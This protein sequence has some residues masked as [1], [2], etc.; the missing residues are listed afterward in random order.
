[1]LQSQDR[2]YTSHSTI[3]VEISGGDGAHNLNAAMVP[4]YRIP[5]FLA[6]SQENKA[7]TTLE[8]LF[9]G[10]AN[11]SGIFIA[12]PNKGATGVVCDS[13]F[14]P[15]INYDDPEYNDDSNSSLISRF[16]YGVNYTVGKSGV[17][18]RTRTVNGV[19]T[20]YLDYSAQVIK[21]IGFAG[22]MYM[23]GFGYDVNNYFVPSNKTVSIQEYSN[24]GG[25]LGITR[26]NHYL[27]SGDVIIMQCSGVPT[28]NGAIG[29]IGVVDRNTFIVN[30]N[31]VTG[32]DALEPPQTGRYSVENIDPYAADGEGGVN[33]WENTV[34][35]TDDVNAWKA[36]PIDLR[37]DASR[38]VWCGSDFFRNDIIYGYLDSDIT[39]ANGRNDP[40]P[41]RIKTYKLAT[42]PT[43]IIDFALDTT[44]TNSGTAM[45]IV[46]NNLELIGGDIIN[47][48]GTNTSYDGEQTVIA[49]GTIETPNDVVYF[50]KRYD[51]GANANVTDIGYIS[52]DDGTLFDIPRVVDKKYI[53]YNYDTHLS[54]ELNSKCAD[55][56]SGCITTQDDIFVVAIKKGPND[57]RPI[58][59][60]FED[61]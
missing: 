16:G 50:N 51:S 48:I 61:K 9:I 40:T 2:Q 17:V 35:F 36:G 44:Y 4:D 41:F 24:Q 56:N 14:F 32:T 45:R 23:A 10:I 52:F 33:G 42:L 39:P 19:T 43:Y 55:L 58:Y 22:P 6:S 59:I 18:T 27:L 12:N 11:K 31:F 15:F 47:I 21:S 57:I 37:W 54:V 34:E 25:K 46:P 20:S 53:V 3:A 38:Q 60:G 5:Y 1:M 30:K 29:V 26:N 13:G 7:A 49:T 28:Y 8:Q